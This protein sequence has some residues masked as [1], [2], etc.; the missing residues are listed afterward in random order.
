M[1]NT[2]QPTAKV[3]FRVPNEDGTTEVETLWATHLGTDQYRLDNSPFW[4]YGVSWADV[5]FAPFS[6]EDGLPTFQAVVR[7]SGNRTVR[8][9][10]ESSL[11]AEKSLPGITALGCSYEGMKN[12]YVAI[13]IPVGIEL[14]SVC[15]YLTELEV[16]W[17][18]ADPNQEE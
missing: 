15:D 11:E 3:L 5:V 7:K 1:K 6:A 9:I 8:V 4:A 18:Y 17:E 13:N 12:R 14:A 2:L 10:F 16:M